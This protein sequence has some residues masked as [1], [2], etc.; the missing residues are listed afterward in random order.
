MQNTSF[1]LGVKT[2][3]NLVS[4]DDCI[5]ITFTRNSDILKD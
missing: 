4:A 5:Q 2:E 3:L 1:W